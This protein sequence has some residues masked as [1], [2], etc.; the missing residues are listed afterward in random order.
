MNGQCPIPTKS[1]KP[2]KGRVWRDGVCRFHHPD[3]EA[4]REAGRRKGGH[5]KSNAARAERRMILAKPYDV[6][7]VLGTSL[8]AVFDGDMDPGT[9]AALATLGRATLLAIEKSDLEKRIAE[10]ERRAGLGEEG[11][12]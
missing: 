2:C 4:E 8:R 1:G 10:L 12:G 9:A 5:N 3:T 11:Q 6:H 7:V